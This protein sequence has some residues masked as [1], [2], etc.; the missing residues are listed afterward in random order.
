MEGK[1]VIIFEVIKNKANW[2]RTFSKQKYSSLMLSLLKEEMML[3]VFLDS[4]SG[5]FGFP[6]LRAK[7]FHLIFRNKFTN[8]A[9]QK[10]AS[11]AGGNTIWFNKT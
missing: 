7:N 8:K 10:N 6:W 2:P 1:K 9:I 11:Y 5:N 3:V 4:H